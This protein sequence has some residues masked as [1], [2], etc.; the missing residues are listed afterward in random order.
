M[1]SFQKRSEKN[2]DSDSTTVCKLSCF[3]KT[4]KTRISFFSKLIAP[5][6]YSPR[7]GLEHFDGQMANKLSAVR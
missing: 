3:E 2:S 1:I 7:L 4:E 5:E 6:L